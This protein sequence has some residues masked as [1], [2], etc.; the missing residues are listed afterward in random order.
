MVEQAGEFSVVVFL[1]DG[2]YGYEKRF[3]DGV[4]AGKSFY[5]HTHSVGARIGTTT[6]V[7]ITDGGD[8]VCFEWIFGLGI[9]FPTDLNIMEG[10][11]N[12]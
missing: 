12:K 8:C 4:T 1:A 3:V 2:S 10:E 6:R 11:R 7:I 9:T 5:H